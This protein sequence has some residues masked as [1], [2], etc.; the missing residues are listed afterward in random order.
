[1]TARCLGIRG[2]RSSGGGRKGGR[3]ENEA[4]NW[5]KG[6][7]RGEERPENRGEEVRGV[8]GELEAVLDEELGEEEDWRM[9]SMENA[10][11]ATLN[12][13]LLVLIC[14]DLLIYNIMR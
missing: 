1:M 8:S 7:R 9:E 12:M 11:A 14:P 2:G 13:K 10:V 4:G 3:Q 5:G 6:D